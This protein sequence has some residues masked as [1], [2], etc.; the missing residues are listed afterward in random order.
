MQRKDQSWIN[1]VEYVEKNI[2][3]YDERQK[4]Q[5]KSLLI[6]RGICKGQNVAN[7]KQQTYGDYPC[8]IILICFKVN[9]I[10][11]MNAIINKDFQSEENKMAYIAAIVKNDIN[12]IYQRWQNMKQSE[13]NVKKTDVSRIV[14]KGSR[15]KR[16]TVD[17]EQYEE[18]W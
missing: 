7:N 3:Q 13:E 2:F 8:E 4:L 15:Y 1:L 6:L 16:K 12:N 14:H 11:I 10:K 17:K 5:K 9:R 18:L